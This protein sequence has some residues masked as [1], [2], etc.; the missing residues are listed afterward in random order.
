MAYVTG[1]GVRYEAPS[2][3]RL[4]QRL[5]AADRPGEHL[6]VLTA[7]W[8]APDPERPRIDMDAENLVSVQGPGCFKCERPYSRRLA[9]KPCR[10][11]ISDLQ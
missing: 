7:A 9:R 6:W 10:G 4:D 1:G 5:E 11:S 2:A 8:I 3:A